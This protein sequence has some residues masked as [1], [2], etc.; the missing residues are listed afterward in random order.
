[1]NDD[2]MSSC[3]TATSD[4]ATEGLSEAEILKREAEKAQAAMA[5]AVAG[6]QKSLGTAADVRLWAERY[7]WLTVGAAV[8]AGFAAGSAITSTVQGRGE[9]N[10]HISP[11]A[12]ASPREYARSQHSALLASL[13]APVFDI[14]KVA[15]QSFIASAMGGAMQAQAQDEANQQRAEETTAGTPGSDAAL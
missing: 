4:F 7:P 12:A 14:A 10:G 1:M 6:L 9:T 5:Q 13:L 8:A 15:V 3:P 2:I 11:Q